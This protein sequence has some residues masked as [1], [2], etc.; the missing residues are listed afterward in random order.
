[1]MPRRRREDRVG[2][3]L[4]GIVLGLLGMA[5]VTLSSGCAGASVFGACLKPV[6]PAMAQTVVEDVIAILANPAGYVEALL[7]LGE[8]FGGKVVDCIVAA[9]QA[10]EKAYPTVRAHAREYVA[11]RLAMGIKLSCK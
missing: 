4:L 3:P 10:D 2:L 8:Q 9:I 1:M 7:Q 6:A 11:K 5:A